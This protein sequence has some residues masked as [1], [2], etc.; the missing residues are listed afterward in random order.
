MENLNQ[1]VEAKIKSKLQ[2]GMINVQTAMTRLTEEG[3]I[4]RDFVFEVGARTKGKESLI[5][6]TPDP[7]YKGT[8]KVGATLTLPTGAEQFQ[9]NMHATGQ[10]AAKLLIPPTYLTML[11]TGE[12]WQKTL[13]YEILNTHN[14][15]LNRSRVLVRAVGTEVRG[16]LSDSY[17]R[18]NSKL[19]FESHIDELYKQ[20]AALSDGYMDDSII[21]AESILP[22]PIVIETELNGTILLAFGA[23]LSTFDY[24]GRAVNLHCFILNGVCLNGAVRE[25]VLREV[26]LGAKLPD[27]LG[28]SERT[29][30]LDSMTTAS[31]VRDLTKQMFAVE[32]IKA[33]MEEIK[34]AS[35]VKVEPVAML[36][37][38]HFTGKLS[39]GEEQAIGKI[40]M[41]NDPMD[42]VQ[43][44]STIWKMTQGIT[45]YANSE[46]V[47]DRRRL[48]LQEVAGNL[49]NKLKY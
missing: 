27:N 12:E 46:D 5:Q 25:S 18:L 4:S 49:F 16:V 39:V 47:A 1:V 43:G 32:T 23:R 26:H 15:Y 48:E 2:K 28:L 45:A 3:K 44:E 13:A 33:R 40:L 41:R 22:Q 10:V 6:F 17:R 35:T 30:E 21:S 36:R 38:L 19:I 7:T 29:Y 37:N 31:A 20:G 34:A 24:G 42:G 9:F 11:L 14:G 8:S